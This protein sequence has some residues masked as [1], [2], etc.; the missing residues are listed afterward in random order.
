[1]R[2]VEFF[3]AVLFGVDRM[4]FKEAT[5]SRLDTIPPPLTLSPASSSEPEADRRL[6]VLI[7]DAETNYIP[8]IRRIWEL[9]N[10]QGA[11]IQF[12]GL[13]KDAAE[14]PAFRRQLVTLSALA[15]NG[16][17]TAEVRIEFG[18]NWLKAVKSNWEKGDMVVCF[19]DERSG[20]LQK[21]LRQILESNL[22]ATVYVFPEF[23]SLDYSRV[24]RLSQ[25]VAWAGSIG[26]IGG[27]FWA[28]MKLTQL[29]QDW[30]HTTLLYLSLF[31]EVVVILL[32]NSL[33]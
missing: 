12:L 27:F 24:N 21:P 31:V 5:M 20:F 14:E 33:F 16:R 23:R 1:M 13:C 19:S 32:W 22:H 10:A 26:I 11:R 30:A 29:P 3:V 15:Q 25:A 9:A 17:V 18:N 4:I 7:P 2:L 28:Q 8:A 6:I